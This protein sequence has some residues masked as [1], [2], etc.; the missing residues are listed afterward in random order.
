MVAALAMLGMATACGSHSHATSPSPSPSASAQAASPAQAASSAPSFDPTAAR[1]FLRRYVTAD[2]RVIRHD[3]GGDVV[4]EGQAYGMLLAEIAG[5]TTKAH[6]IWNWTR[7]HLRNADGLISWHATGDGKVLDRQSATD[8][9]VLIAYALLRYAGA[10]ADAFHQAGRD[11]AAAVFAHESLTLPDRNPVL[12]A[13]PWAVSDGVVDP[14]Y[15]MP[16]VFDGLASMTGDRRWA[17]AADTAVALVSQLT[18]AGR[19]LPPDWARLQG[20]T[21]TPTPAP[22]GTPSTQYGLD[23]QRIPVWFATSCSAPARKLAATWWSLLSVGDGKTAIALSLD[24]QVYNSAKNPLSM[25]AA[26]ATAEAAGDSASGHGLMASAAAQAT[27]APTY[28]GDAW[29]ALGQALLDGK[30]TSCPQH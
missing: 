5:D 1:A 4:S 14:S 13:G 17:Q 18:D 3:Q 25:V 21:L 16:A 15:W 30:L 10:D 28:Y 9:D 29:L 2:G 8:A 11:I 20:S 19:R 27:Q 7:T 23:A 22:G 6:A 12:A 24:G 26:A